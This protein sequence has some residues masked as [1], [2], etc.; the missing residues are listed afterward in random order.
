MLS[1]LHHVNVIVVA[2]M[3]ISIDAVCSHIQYIRV[4]YACQDIVRVDQQE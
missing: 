4:N 1:H 2:R 3:N